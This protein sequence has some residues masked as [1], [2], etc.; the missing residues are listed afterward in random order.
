MLKRHVSCLPDDDTRTRSILLSLTLEAGL[1][2]TN[3]AGSPFDVLA[4]SL[5]ASHD[6][7]PSSRLWEFLDDCILRFLKKPVHY[8][9]MFTALDV[10]PGSIGEDQDKPSISLFHLVVQEQWP[11]VLKAASHSEVLN[12]ASWISRYLNFS[13]HIGESKSLLKYVRDR[14]KEQMKDKECRAL[15]SIAL[16][17]SEDFEARYK[18]RRI[19]KT[20][21]KAEE[22]ED[23]KQTGILSASEVAEVPPPSQPLP[24]DDS[25]RGLQRWRATDMRESVEDGAVGELVLCLCSQ[26][27]EI[28]KQALISL[29]SFLQMLEVGLCQDSV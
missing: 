27:E 22:L 19:H 25:H 11:F 5:Q 23:I 14:V 4:S 13:L 28:R 1:I 6:W 16:K 9:D 8:Y 24:E 3:T 10:F 20:L 21:P 29:R 17:G 26:H 12:I 15:I 18:P 7:K 2:K